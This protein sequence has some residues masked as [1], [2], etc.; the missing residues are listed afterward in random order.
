M[1]SF[2]SFF[3]LH[4]VS[5]Y[6]QANEVEKSAVFLLPLRKKSGFKSWTR[7]ME[8]NIWEKESQKVI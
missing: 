7:E 8:M 3:C 6:I 1:E 5:K 4:F 2:F